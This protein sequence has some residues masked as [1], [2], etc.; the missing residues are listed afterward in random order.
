MKL[1]KGKI[2]DLELNSDFNG[3]QDDEMV[4][5]KS[6]YKVIKADAAKKGDLIK[7][8]KAKVVEKEAEITRMLLTAKPIDPKTLGSLQNHVKITKAR[9]SELENFMLDAKKR[10]EEFKSVL[11]KSV[12]ILFARQKSN[13]GN[14]EDVLIDGVEAGVITTYAQQISR[15][16]L[17]MDWDSVLETSRTPDFKSTRNRLEK[18]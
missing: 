7:S 18:L 16:Y 3:A 12:E 9:M 15:K 17:Q 5:L 13:E 6:N 14:Q 4:T 11:V 1:L 8:L 10:E 2:E